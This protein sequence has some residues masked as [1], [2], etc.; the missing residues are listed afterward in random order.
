MQVNE[1]TEDTHI[2]VTLLR[3]NETVGRMC[4]QLVGGLIPGLVA[5]PFTPDERERG[6]DPLV[7]P[8]LAHEVLLLMARV[9]DCIIT[10]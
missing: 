2:T 4:L 9:H 5:L 1:V 10:V 7:G 3:G 6:L 8:L